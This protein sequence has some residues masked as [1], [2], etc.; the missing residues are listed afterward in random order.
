MIENYNREKRIGN[1]KRVIGDQEI[2]DWRL[3]IVDLGI[4]GE[5]FTLWE[6]YSRMGRSPLTGTRFVPRNEE[7]RMGE[8]Q[9]ERAGKEGKSK[10][11]R[12]FGKG[13]LKLLFHIFPRNERK[14]EDK[15]PR[16]GES[17]AA[18]AYEYYRTYVLIL[19]GGDRKCPGRRTGGT[20]SHLLTAASFRT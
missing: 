10:R 1:R 5:D 8:E 4:G 16:N 3:E 18:C 20:R 9:G 11:E 13:E 14:A 19:Q 17:Q 15:G 12:G 7:E 6:L 2:E